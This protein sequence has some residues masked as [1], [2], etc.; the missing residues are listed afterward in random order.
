MKKIIIFFILIFSFNLLAEYSLEDLL[1][2]QDYYDILD[3]EEIEQKKGEIRFLRGEAYLESL[4]TWIQLVRRDSINAGDTMITLDNTRVEVAIDKDIDIIIGEKTK[5]YFENLE[6]DIRTEEVND[7]SLGL[8]FGT[9][10]SNVRRTLTSGGKFE[11]NS[12]SV[13]AG[14][15]GTQFRIRAFRNG[16]IEVRVFKGRVEVRD[17]I[18][19]RRREVN[20]REY[21][22]LDNKGNI[23]EAGEHD[24]EFAESEEV[25][26]VE[27]EEGILDDSS[28]IDDEADSLD[29][30]D[31]IDD[32]EDFAF[33]NLEGL[34]EQLSQVSD[35]IQ[36]IDSARELTERLREADTIQEE[37]T[38]RVI[39][40][41]E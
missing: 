30:V 33:D 5:V 39:I 26:E 29:S 19:E 37:L 15:R 20:E 12:G 13:V 28:D 40:I 1:G 18:T 35:N 23:L 4:D 36:I 21:I 32:F 7:T 27:E 16:R 3:M 34:E 2:G 14:V 41:V 9:V 8:L 25:E 38:N 10:Y 31:E 17:R 22:I 24:S 6:G 11:V